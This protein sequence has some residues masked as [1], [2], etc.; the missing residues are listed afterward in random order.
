LSA[1]RVTTPAAWNRYSYALNNPLKYSDPSG[2]FEWDASLT[3]DPTLTDKERVRRK[4][5]RNAFLAARAQ[6]RA[7]AVKG[8][9]SKKISQAKYDKIISALDSYGPEPGQPGSNNGV[10]VGLGPADPKNMAETE[11]KFEVDNGTGPGVTPM[12]KVLF[13]EAGLSKD[14]ASIVV[15]HEGV[16]VEDA[17]SY[18]ASRAD[19]KKLSIAEIVADP[20]NPTQYELERRAFTVQSYLYQAMG[21]N[22][23]KWKTWEKGWAKLTEQQQNAKRAEWVETTI[24]LNYKIFPEHPGNDLSS[25]ECY[26]CK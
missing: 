24:G 25:H 10:S 8:L 17:L 16:H 12:I 11:A 5:L 3:D 23:S 14:L 6:A 20:R 2:L 9:E 1:S 13:S 4:G 22:D 18:A 7:D 19:L 26:P 15:T 21:Q